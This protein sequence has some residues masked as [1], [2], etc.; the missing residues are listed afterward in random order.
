MNEQ[1]TEV[2]PHTITGAYGKA[3]VAVSRSAEWVLPIVG[4][5]LFSGQRRVSRVSVGA[6]AEHDDPS[7][8]TMGH[9]ISTHV[10]SQHND[11]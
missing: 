5:P 6:A 1:W 10:E 2:R 9:R 4:L 7:D 8:E 11:S 3:A